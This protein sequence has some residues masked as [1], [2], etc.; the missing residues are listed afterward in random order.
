[1][2]EYEKEDFK[3]PDEVNVT[4]KSNNEIDI[5]IE[6]D[7]PPEDRNRQPM[8][9]DIVQSL[10]NDNLEAEEYSA[11]AREKLK[12]LKKVWN[13]ERRAKEAALREHQ[14]AINFARAM[15]EE[16]KQFKNLI[17]IGEKEYVSSISTTAQLELEKAKRLYKDAY[18]QGDSDAMVAAQEIMQNANLRLIQARNF[19][20]PTLQ[21][22][23]FPV[24]NSYPQES[25]VPQPDRKAL[26]WQQRNQWFGQDKEMTAAAL[27][28]HEKLRDDGVE[29]G[30]TA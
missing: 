24:Q 3:F 16:N 20:L 2:A 25:Q 30:S 22:T 1:M 10:E 4:E 7:T 12:Q 17:S 26:S 21:N 19:K 14:E 11:G 27:G 28:L 29:I 8:P 23:E 13:D 6:D 18:D 5:E 15:A 9:E